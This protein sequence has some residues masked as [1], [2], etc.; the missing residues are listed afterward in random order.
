VRVFD[1]C[2]VYTEILCRGSVYASSFSSA[3]LIDQLRAEL[4]Q[5]AT[6]AIDLL[7]RLGLLIYAG[8]ADRYVL[9]SA[10]KLVAKCVIAFDSSTMATGSLFV[11]LSLA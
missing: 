11:C 1:N 8:P 7:Q 3:D 5:S 4:R 6:S 10:V 9:P 2:Q